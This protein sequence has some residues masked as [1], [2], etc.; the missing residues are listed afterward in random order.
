[1]Q[2]F[3]VRDSAR[4]VDDAGRQRV[5]RLELCWGYGFLKG[6]Y[7]CNQVSYERGTPVDQVSREFGQLAAHTLT[8]ARE[9]VQRLEAL[10][11]WNQGFV[12]FTVNSLHYENHVKLALLSPIYL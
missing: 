2:G 5:Q 6:R 1:M 7:P 11:V 12:K 3:G 10:F 9:R 8:E 4:D